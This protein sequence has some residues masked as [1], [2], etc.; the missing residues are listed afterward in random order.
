MPLNRRLV[1]LLLI[2][3]AV[4]APVPALAGGFY[5]QEQSPKETGRALSGGAA[6]GDDPST[7]YFNPAAMTQLS[8]IQTSIGGVALMASAHQDNRGTTRTIPGISTAV[9]VSGNAGG[10]PFEKV[11]PRSEERRVGKEC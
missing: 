4:A 8:G 5:L 10:N 2:S 9:P 3:G 11:I 1:S 7:V 6:A